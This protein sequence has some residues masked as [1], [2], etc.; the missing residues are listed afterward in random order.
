MDYPKS[1]EFIVIGAGIIGAGAAYHLS[2]AGKDVIVLDAN[3]VVSQASGRNGGMVVQ[4]DARDAN[5]SV[6]KAKLGFARKAIEELKNYEREL[7]IDF[8]FEQNG[9]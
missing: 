9:S 1:A 4:L 2:K 3:E 8:A 7:D 5:V 6:M